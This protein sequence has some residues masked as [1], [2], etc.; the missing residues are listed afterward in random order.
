MER[1]PNTASLSEGLRNVLGMDTALLDRAAELIAAADAALAELASLPAAMPCHPQEALDRVREVERLSRRVRSVEL[2]VADA[3]DRSEVWRADGH[4]KAHQLVAHAC[5]L[6]YGEELR[7]DQSMRALRDLPAVATALREGRI[8]RCRVERIA[9][10]W[11]NE[12]VRGR[13]IDLDATLAQQA[14]QWSLAELHAHL[15]DWEA[16]VDEAGA[17][18][19]AA[20]NHADRSATMSQRDDGGWDGAWR[21]GSLDGA[22]LEDIWR[23]FCDAEAAADWDEAKARQGLAVSADDLVRT[24]AQRR[25]DALGRIFRLAADGWSHDR[26]GP[27]IETIIVI[28]EE[29]FVRHLRRTAGH[30]PPPPRIDLDGNRLAS[31][32][33]SG[34]HPPPGCARCDDHL[35]PPPEGAERRG[36][37]VRTRPPDE[38][39]V[40][41][42]ADV[43]AALDWR[44][45]HLEHLERSGGPRHEPAPCTRRRSTTIDGRFV[46]PTEAIA[47]ALVGHVR[48]AVVDAESVTIDLGRRQRLFA[49]YASL[50]AKLAATACYWVGCRVPTGRCQTDH[51]HGWSAGGPT[52]QVNAGPA[53]GFH[54]RYKEHGYTVRRDPVFRTVPHPP[55]GWHRDRLTARR[56]PAPRPAAGVPRCHPTRVEMEMP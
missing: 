55:P 27:P 2:A 28:D 1:H 6:S 16:T 3:V 34:G 45:E 12:R 32:P 56:S 48:R 47:A 46:D 13:L 51:L 49:G 54:N 39:E 38:D 37:P 25:F 19:R 21:C 15:R 33:A 17:A 8:G 52:D 44:T 7:R 53:C 20:R 29:T 24:D 26:G 35:T 4:R 23:A 18:E 41:D 11:A 40:V 5:H 36:D 50:A 14:S 31:P 43:E 42:L 22:Q 9:R 30:L 10:T